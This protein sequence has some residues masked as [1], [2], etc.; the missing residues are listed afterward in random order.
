MK[1][2]ETSIIFTKFLLFITLLFSTNLNAVKQ[3]DINELDKYNPEDLCFYKN[4][5]YD[6]RYS[7]PT[8]P[9]RRGI[10]FDCNFMKYLDDF[11]YLDEKNYVDLTKEPS[12]KSKFVT[13][14]TNDHR[15]EA[16]FLLDSFEKYFPGEKIIV[17]GMGMKP[18]NR[19][20]L[21][22][23][24]YVEYRDFD[25]S[26]YPKH[27]A[28]AKSY[29]FKY[30][31]AS[32]VLKEYKGATWV[33]SSVRFQKKGFMNQIA[34]LWD[35]YK[36]R[37]PDHKHKEQLK[38]GKAKRLEN[39]KNVAVNRTCK[40]KCFL[41]I[42]YR[43]NNRK[44]F[45]FNVKHCYKAPILLHIPTF[46]GITPTIFP[47]F[48]EYFPTDFKQYDNRTG[49]QYSSGFVSY[50]KS[51]DAIDS[52]LS[53]AVLCS[54]TPSCT[55][56]VRWFPCGPH[57]NKNNLFAKHHVCHRFDQTLLTVLL[58]NSNN[59]DYRNYVTEIHDYADVVWT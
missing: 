40:K 29:A 34:K 16:Q 8:D 14:I 10:K 37:L 44:L 17:Y 24:K 9:K 11:G 33:D 47:K 35:C 3:I 18:D 58:H 52:F 46:H 6:L 22:A 21:K 23:L 51:K 38:L 36:G 26:K 57:F 1:K 19:K 56:P 7:M 45:N 12:P 59:F 2:L 20:S 39:Y 43:G 32:E 49:R 27:V 13:G 5:T 25:T 31:I 50:V 41:L 53:W 28:K 30:L 4:K 42:K 54:L 48:S 15:K 55:E